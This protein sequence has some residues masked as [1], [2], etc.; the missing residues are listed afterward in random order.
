MGLWGIP[1]R[2]PNEIPNSVDSLQLG[3]QEVRIRQLGL[4]QEWRV[5]GDCYDTKWEEDKRRTQAVGGVPGWEKLK[6]SLII[7]VY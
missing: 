4:R 6:E 5:W 7:R 3:R 2:P 1:R